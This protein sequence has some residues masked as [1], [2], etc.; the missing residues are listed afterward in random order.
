MLEKGTLARVN[1]PIRTEDDRLAVIEGLKDGTIDIIATDHA[2]HHLTEKDRGFVEAPF[3]ISGLETAVAI[4]MTDLVKKNVITPLEMAD[5][6]SYTP[7][8]I[9]GIDV[10]QKLGMGTVNDVLSQFF[11]EQ[12]VPYYNFNKARLSVL[13]LRQRILRSLTHLIWRTS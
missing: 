9:I 1:P 13:H 5:K 6:M 11:E 3:G 10:M 12:N 2:P 4:I 8:K 7:A